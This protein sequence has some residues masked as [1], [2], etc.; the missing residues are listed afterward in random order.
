MIYENAA[1]HSVLAI[2]PA[3][4]GSK[5]IPRKN[6]RT[7]A[8]KPLLEYTARAAL[9]ATSLSRILL[10]TDDPEIAAI[11]REAGLEVPFL[12]PHG[13]ALDSTPMVQ[14]VSHALE[15]TRSQGLD[16]E[17]VCVLQPT[18]PLRSTATIDRCISLLWK[19]DVDSVISVRPVPPEYNPHWVY[20][21]SPMGLLEPSIKG[22]EILCRQQLPPA[23]HPD[24][25]VFVTKTEV[26][27]AERSLRGKRTMGAI[28]PADEA[29]DLDT[30]EQWRGLEQKLKSTYH[31]SD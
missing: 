30:D 31:P 5:G 13:L 29:I 18:S 12:R 25:S 19:H 6:I 22:A 3:R 10:S 21:E 17:A 23:Y 1:P 26:V 11:G 15:W 27:M 16:Y 8:G 28:S 4:G 24:G 9:G 7:M 14:V 2:V 20:F